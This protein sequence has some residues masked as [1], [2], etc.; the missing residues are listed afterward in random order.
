MTHASFQYLDVC[1]AHFVARPQRYFFKKT[2]AIATLLHHNEHLVT[3]LGLYE[4]RLDVCKQNYSNGSLPFSKNI[5]TFSYNEKRECNFDAHLHNRRPIMRY[6]Q[7]KED[8][9]KHQNEVFKLVDVFVKLQAA[10]RRKLANY[11]LG[12]Q[13]LAVAVF[14][15]RND[16]DLGDCR[17]LLWRTHYG[18]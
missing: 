7:Q 2:Q 9:W 10:R 4:P 8:I 15:D 11:S 1:P 16:R 3:R 6:P 13:T 5:Y 12:P 14:T 18:D 17:L